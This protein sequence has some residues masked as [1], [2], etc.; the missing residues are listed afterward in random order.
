MIVCLG[1]KEI[2]QD[3]GEM[4]KGSCMRL[5]WFCVEFFKPIQ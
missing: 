2:L 5:V 1:K 4:G 3:A